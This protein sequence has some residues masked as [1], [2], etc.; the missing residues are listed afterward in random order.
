M[1]TVDFQQILAAARQLSKSSQAELVSALLQ[2]PEAAHTA[3]L[4]PL[5][6]LSEAELGSLAASM[7]APARVR[8][9]Q[10]LLRL[11]REK[12]LTR[13]LQVEAARDPL[14]GR[15]VRLSH[16]HHDVW[17]H[18]LAWSPDGAHII[19]LTPTGRAT[20]EALRFNRPAMILLRR[21]WRATGVQFGE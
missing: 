6:G 2:E 14:S 18:H 15:A 9:L 4:E 16:P 19:G 7:F 11:H 12:K 10:Q 3:A 5:T 8:R 21:Y 20:A 17:S 13:A 1:A